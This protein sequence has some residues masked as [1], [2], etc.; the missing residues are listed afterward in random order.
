MVVEE[1]LNRVIEPNWSEQD[2]KP[3]LW[4]ELGVLKKCTEHESYK[5]HELPKI[6]CCY[7][8]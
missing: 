6:E 7:K 1:K 2:D 5:N 8:K 3:Y 4:W